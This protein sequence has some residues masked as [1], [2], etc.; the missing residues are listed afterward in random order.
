MISPVK[1]QA[2]SSMQAAITELMP[3]KEAE[4]TSVGG[5]NTALTTL[6]QNEQAMSH[7]RRSFNPTSRDDQF[8]NLFNDLGSTFS[9]DISTD[10]SRPQRVRLDEKRGTTNHEQYFEL[11]KLNA[12]GTISSAERVTLLTKLG[13]QADGATSIFAPLDASGD[14]IAG[15]GDKLGRTLEEVILTNPTLCSEFT[16]DK[17]VAGFRTTMSSLPAMDRRI[18]EVPRA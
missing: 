17:V 7:L 12:L 1:E 4:I 11:K 15:L 18:V 10:P 6:M 13:E 14:A 5:F 3:A 9:L 8:V 2:I 16:A